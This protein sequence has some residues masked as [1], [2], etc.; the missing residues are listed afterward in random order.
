[1]CVFQGFSSLFLSVLVDN[2]LA[3]MNVLSS[4]TPVRVISTC[5]VERGLDSGIY[6]ETK[7]VF[8][9]VV[10]KMQTASLE[11]YEFAH[12]RGRERQTLCYKHNIDIL[13]RRN[14]FSKSVVVESSP[15]CL[16]HSLVNNFVLSL[17]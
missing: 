12:R 6:S 17:F 15:E 5:V 11:F 14:M 13:L 4:T 16:P 2:K 10:Y 7:T 9:V 3:A 1:M 8:I